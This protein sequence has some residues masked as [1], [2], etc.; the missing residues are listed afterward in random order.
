MV[1]DMET[2]EKRTQVMRV[3]VDHVGKVK[4]KVPV[5]VDVERVFDPAFSRRWFHLWSDDL[6]VGGTGNTAS[7]A[8][9]DLEDTILEYHKAGDSMV[10]DLIQ[11][12]SPEPK[13]VQIS[14]LY[15][16]GIK[17]MPKR[18]VL[19]AARATSDALD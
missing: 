14:P 11:S 8:W 10:S 12:V 4:F 15:C 18:K 19:Y 16:P 7:E 5:L 17:D 1:I 13:P 2:Y 3:R 6:C 9:D